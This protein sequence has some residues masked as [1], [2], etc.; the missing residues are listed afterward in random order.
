MR[1]KKKKKSVT[2]KSEQKPK[3]M[4]EAE[5]AVLSERNKKFDPNATADDCVRDLR[6][7]Q[8]RFP[9][10]HITRNF[11]RINGKYSDATFNQFFGTFLEF[12]RQAGL[13]LSRNQHSLERKIAKHASVD[14]YRRFYEQEVLPYQKKFLVSESDK[15]RFKTI[16]IGSDFHDVDADPFVLSVFL[17]VASRVQPD[18]IVLNGDVFDLYEASRFNIDLRHIKI[19]ERFNFVKT[20]IF[21]A[22]RRACPNS[23]IDLIAGNHEHRLMTLLSDKT[24]AMKVLLSDVMGLSLSDVFGLDEF[25]INFIS[26]A[27]LAAWSAS[28]IDNELK[29]NYKVYFNSFVASHFK[30]LAFG[31][32]GTSGHTHRPE[33]VTF[34]NIPMGKLSWTTTGCI[35]KTEVEYVPGMDKWTNSFMLA[36]IDTQNRIVSPE[37]FMIPGEHVVIHGKL[38]T[39]KMGKK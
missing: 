21:G 12:R 3:K 35:A 10:K 24:P 6:A 19:L 14:I 11:Y 26:K 39:K 23:Q 29:Q 38:Y 31:L 33:M 4:S 2:P 8:E 36:H 18:V 22:L 15:K 25:E 28:D 20:H 1:E 9:L 27:N 17:D 30:E 7:L 5:R 32:S 37:H 13:E 34:A 16:L